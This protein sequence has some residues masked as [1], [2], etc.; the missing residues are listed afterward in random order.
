MRTILCLSCCAALLCVATSEGVARADPP[1]GESNDFAIDNAVPVDCAQ[2]M[3]FLIDNRGA[4]CQP[5]GS[6]A[7]TGQPECVAPGFWHGDLTS[8]DPNPCAPACRGDANCDGGINWRDI[9]YF[10]AAMSGEQSW[11]DMFLPGTP[12]CT[13]ANNDVNGDGVVN[14]RDIDP[15]V[16]VMGTSCP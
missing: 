1:C 16:A 12:G 11:R 5:G 3:T 2:S 8:C 14:W 9:D 7:L 4:C 13:Y 10:V 6:C 15:F